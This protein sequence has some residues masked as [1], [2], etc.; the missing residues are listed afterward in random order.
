MDKF[1]EHEK[2]EA[3]SDESQA[4]HD[5]L[6]FL[7]E[8]GF[9]FCQDLDYVDEFEDPMTGKVITYTGKR[10]APVAVDRRNL[11]AEFFEIDLDK[12]EEEKRT[13]LEGLRELSKKGVTND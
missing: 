13:M 3:I 8:K 4:C 6:E 2:L 11:L 12:L 9:V 5:F 10:L 7:N 1:P